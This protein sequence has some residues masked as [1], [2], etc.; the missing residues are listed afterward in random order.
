[1]KIVFVCPWYGPDIPGGAEAE[2][3][4]TVENLRQRGEAVEVWTTCL[5]DFEGDW[6]FNYY[7]AG[8]DQV[9]GV[10]VKR[11]PVGPRNGEL[12]ATLN[13]QVLS[14]ARL[15]R[16]EEKL[17]FE[18]MIQSPALIHQIQHQGHNCLFF[19]IP[20]LFST[21]F[22]GARIHPDR[23]FI[24][25]CLHDEGY[26]RLTGLG[27]AFHRVRGLIFHTR[28]EMALGQEL[29]SLAK[30]QSHLFGEGIDTDLDYD[31]E[32][33]RSKYQLKDP[34][35]LYAGRR[36]GGKNTPLL[37]QYFAWFKQRHPSDLKLVLIGNLPVRIPPGCTDILDYGFVPK[38][39]KYDAYGA[40]ALFCQPSVLESFS[41][42]IMES[43]LCGRPILVNAHCPVTVEHCR[44]SQ[45]GLYFGNYPEF[46]EALL[47]LLHN[48]T[49]ARTLAQ[50]GK[51][52]VL[53]RF[54]WDQIS[55]KYRDLIQQAREALAGT[56]GPKEEEKPVKPLPKTS[57]KALHQML[58][59]F[60]YGDAIGNDVLNI[61]KVLRGWGHP[62]DI[63]A[64]H[65]HAKL[66]GTARPYGEYLK[67]GG[68]DQALLFHFSIGSELS[69]FVKRLPDRKILI[70]HNITPPQFFKGFNAEV[71]RRCAWGYEEL[72][73][74]A[75]HFELA[76][77][78][79]DFNRRELEGLGFRKTGV[80]PIL[81]DFNQYYLS[82]EEGLKQRLQDGTLNILHVGRLV[83][84]KKIEDLIRVFYLF[85]KR[86]HPQSRLLLV[87]TD[88]GL[89]NY[90]SAL[91]RMVRELGLT[92]KVHFEGFATFRGLIT[93]YANAHLY[94]CLSEHEGFCVPLLESMFFGLPIIAYLT[95]GVPETLG[96]SG[97]GISE[98]K[99]DEIAEGMAL[100][101]EDQR[102]REKI[103]AAQKEQLKRFSWDKTAARLKTLLDP[104]LEGS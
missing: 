40:A 3:R 27:E 34:F 100:I 57:K 12:F 48:R 55:R 87:G 45:G 23:S 88:S 98:K 37:M 41:I 67:A 90:S 94:L 71:E 6:A 49:L 58:P 69:E 42:V 50:N 60:S 74:M 1:M 62:S 26:A 65:V 16:E 96:G 79:S 85:Q 7:P 101:I 4:R 9:N 52:Y 53:S 8:D 66:A 56:S 76:L 86:H 30:N 11:F 75:P 18:H 84:Q 95:G 47:E 104:F 103:V 13:R 21:T 38:Q 102:L 31:P 68:P 17:F 97:I 28:V 73:K 20:Y 92:E 33:F 72:K 14:G 39:D 35:V 61:Q 46:E 25:P 78:V 54:H 36:D 10:P 15:S 29:F 93:Y 5:K 81:L 32:R 51:A 19:F 82:P 2:A 70:Y 80:L 22:F 91:K 89:K 83:P 99:W 24:I 63:Y 77:G 64:H 43:W 44:E 59:D